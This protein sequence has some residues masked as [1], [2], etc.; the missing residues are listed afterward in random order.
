M[1]RRSLRRLRNVVPLMPKPMPILRRALVAGLLL[2]SAGAPAQT[3]AWRIGDL[4]VSEA[5]ARATPAR[6]PTGAAFL[7][8]VNN[9][10]EAD[11]L[12]DASSPVAEKVMLHAHHAH[13]G[14]MRMREQ[15]DIPI[16]PG[17][18]VTLR[19]GEQHIMLLGLKGPL[20]RGERFPLQLRFE[21]AGSVQID[22]AVASAGA[23]GPDLTTK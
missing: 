12:L 14:V 3:P 7:T 17:S 4:V 15:P 19:P 9:G 8:I 21:R 11:R 13:D 23:S 10:R 5:W 18:T 16:D 2:L 6:A 1:L 20:N 22:V